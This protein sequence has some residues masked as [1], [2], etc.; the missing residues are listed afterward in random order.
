MNKKEE[1][2]GDYGVYGA[3]WRV[4][5]CYHHERMQRVDVGF[6]VDLT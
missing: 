5:S 3:N 2:E 6:L 1:E 4:V